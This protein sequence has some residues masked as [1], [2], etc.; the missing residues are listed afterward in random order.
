M[1]KYLLHENEV[2]YLGNHTTKKKI[3]S[4]ANSFPNKSP[5]P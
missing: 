5:L 4:L 3:H 2:G 1:E